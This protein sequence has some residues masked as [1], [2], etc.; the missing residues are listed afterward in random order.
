MMS[1]KN[2]QQRPDLIIF[3]MDGTT[4]RHINPRILTVLEKIDDAMFWLSEYINQFRSGKK[5]PHNESNA[6]KR[7][8][9][10]LLV[11]RALHKIRRK[12]VEQI[13]E[14]CP[15]IEEL[16]RFFSAHAIPLGLVS[17][18]LGKGYGHDILQKFGLEKYFQASLFRED[19]TNSKP[20]PEPLLNLLKA[21]NF[22]LSDHHTIWI[23]GDRK[24]DIKCALKLQEMTKAHIVPL[25]YGIE[26]A[27]S[28]L[29]YQLPT[30][31]IITSY[32]DFYLKCQNLLGDPPSVPNEKN[33]NSKS[34]ET[35]KISQPHATMAA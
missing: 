31:F 8:P 3:D 28:I 21:L 20:H 4:V 26:A 19:F 15:D 13:V 14:P 12:P 7:K 2:L 25:S 33:E 22:S 9:K 24:K 1:G 11:H 32:H 6:I 34:Q 17:N 5:I 29:K 23:I 35:S 30:D 27:I 16:L 18:G 10:R